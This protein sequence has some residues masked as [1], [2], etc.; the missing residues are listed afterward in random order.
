MGD[1]GRY[2]GIATVYQKFTGTTSKEF[3][4]RN[5]TDITKKNI[6][7]VIEQLEEKVG[8]K[9][10]KK[11]RLFLGDISVEATKPG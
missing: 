6:Q 1:D 7:I 9:V 11:W 4:G 5:Y 10:I 3:G 2:Y 8:D